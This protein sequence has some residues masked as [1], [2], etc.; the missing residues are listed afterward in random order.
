MVL[1]VI[2]VFVLVI[3]EHC[4]IEL[5]VGLSQF[6]RRVSVSALDG[7][8]YLDCLLNFAGECCSF[9]CECLESAA[10]H[11]LQTVDAVLLIV[12]AVGVL[13]EFAEQVGVALREIGAV[14]LLHFEQQLQVL[15][16]V[17]DLVAVVLHEDVEQPVLGLLLLEQVEH[18]EFLSEQVVVFVG[19]SAEV[20]APE[21][22][23]ERPDG[24]GLLLHFVRVQVEE[25]RLVFAL[26]AFGAQLKEV[27]DQRLLEVVV[28]LTV[29]FKWIFSV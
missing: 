2:G 11:G 14:T 12:D 24:V 15:E 6:E 10:L 16:E 29:L 27:F 3:D 13:I 26:H 4:F 5:L 21:F 1:Q 8:S 23:S 19:Q 18:L 20:V 28:A 25:V 7:L 22:S 9:G 17:L